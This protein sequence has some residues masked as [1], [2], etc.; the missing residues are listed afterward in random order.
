MVERDKGIDALALDIVRVSD[1]GRLGH[2]LV[3]DEGAL[4]LGGPDAVSRD[5]D[6]IVYSPHEPVVAFLV[7]PGAVSREVRAREPLEVG[8]AEPVRFAVDAA[9]DPRPGPADDQETPFV[10]LAPG[11]VLPH[12]LGVHPRERHGGRTRLGGNGPG[13]RRDEN[14]AGLGLPPGVYHGAPLLADDRV[15]PHPGLGVYRLAHRAKDPKAAQVVL[16]RPLAS[17]AGQCAYDRRGGVEHI[18]PVLRDDLPEPVRLRVCG[19]PLV[20]EGGETGCERA[21]GDV[22]VARDPPDV[23]RAPEGVLVPGV[24]DPLEGLVHVEQVSCR[25]VHDPFG[26]ARAPARVEDEQGV[27][28]IHLLGLALGRNIRRG[29]Q[30]IQ[31]E[32]AARLHLHRDIGTAHHDDLLHARAVLERLVG[33][34]LEADDLPPP[35]APVRNDE[36]IRVGVLDPVAER[37]G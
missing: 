13:E 31:P 24:E 26:L 1:H 2:V 34:V 33:V 29:E 6:H 8:C 3:G 4:H 15:V 35:K 22:T 18:H 23:G 37:F 25:G 27:L 10:R 17:V 14:S 16:L 32:V 11:A 28:R 30:L 19:D 21:V 20:H 9:H 36:E 7:D 12:D 5:V